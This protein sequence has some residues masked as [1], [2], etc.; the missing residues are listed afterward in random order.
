MRKEEWSFWAF[1]V[2]GGISSTGSP[3]WR[4]S[5]Q[6]EVVATCWSH[7]Y[8]AFSNSPQILNF[9]LHWPVNSLLLLPSGWDMLSVTQKGPTEGFKQLWNWS[10]S[11]ESELF[12]VPTAAR[13]WKSTG[14]GSIWLYEFW[15]II[16]KCFTHMDW[17][18]LQRSH[19]RACPVTWK[20]YVFNIKVWY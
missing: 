20:E 4:Q 15:I 3:R 19:H 12:L 9:P 5:E 6:D 1:H 2:D 7:K 17:G 13:V 11:W 10:E 8:K 14:K 16:I 18:L